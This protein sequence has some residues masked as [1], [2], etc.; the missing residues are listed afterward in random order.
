MNAQE[1]G[2]MLAL[3]KRGRRVLLESLEGV[4][5]ETALRAPA[6]GKWTILDCIEHLAVSED[7]LF[8]QIAGATASETSAIPPQREALIAERALDRTRRFESPEEL[9]PAGRFPTLAASLEHFLA[10][11]DRTVR[12]VEG[13]RENLRSRVT[14]H[15]LVGPATCYEMLL[16]LALHPLRH[17]EQIEEIKAGLK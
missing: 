4:S 17:A 8:S 13:N 10:S 11:R 7:Y 9:R 1:K 2:K 15:P 12:F 5:A 16:M 6:P 3:L 14:A